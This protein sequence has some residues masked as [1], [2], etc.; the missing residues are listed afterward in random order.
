M[1]RKSTT[2][3]QHPCDKDHVYH[4]ESW[5]IE[6]VPARLEHSRFLFNEYLCV[7]IEQDIITLKS[8]VCLDLWNLFALLSRTLILY[9]ALLIVHGNLTYNTLPRL[10]HSIYDHNFHQ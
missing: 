8:L 2:S 5:D 3:E 6:K 9:V 10:P 4:N 7:A 1:S